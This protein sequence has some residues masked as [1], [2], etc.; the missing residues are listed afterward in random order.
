MKRNVLVEEILDNFSLLQIVRK[1]S[2]CLSV[3]VKYLDDKNN[4]K[5]DCICTMPNSSIQIGNQAIAIFS[6]D[7]SNSELLNIYDLKTHTYISPKKQTKVYQ[8]RFI[9]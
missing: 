2:K 8:K 9:D 5:K 3:F 4:L 7:A 1:N 6:S